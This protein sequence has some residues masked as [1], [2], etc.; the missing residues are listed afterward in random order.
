MRQALSENLV[1][2]QPLS[3][4]DRCCVW[5]YVSSMQSTLVAGHIEAKSTVKADKIILSILPVP[6][7]YIRYYFL[8]LKFSHF[9]TPK[10][11]I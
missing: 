9:Y 8:I 5:Y 1:R 6:S 11:S 10:T 4:C 2:R 7:S 3:C